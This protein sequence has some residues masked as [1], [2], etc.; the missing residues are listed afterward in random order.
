M[1][2]RV[3]RVARVAAVAVANAPAMSAAASASI[4]STATSAMPR[5][6]LRRSG[7]DS[8]SLHATARQHGIGGIA[9]HGVHR[10]VCRDGGEGSHPHA[11]DP[12]FVR[13][14]GNQAISQ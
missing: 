10:A 3:V 12:T 13:P 6:A 14:V 7:G 9:S 8:A 2:A 5:L 11:R 1:A 4:P